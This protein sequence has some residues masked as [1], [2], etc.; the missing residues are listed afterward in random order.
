[1]DD[2]MVT[3]RDIL[4]HIRKLNIDIIEIEDGDKVETI[5]VK[6]CLE[7]GKLKIDEKE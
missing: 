1:M 4:A 3:M 6:K 5:D 7:T 2:K